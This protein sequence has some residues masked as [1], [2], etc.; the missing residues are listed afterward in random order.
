MFFGTERAEKTRTPKNRCS[1]FGRSRRTWSRL[2]ARS[3]L[4]HSCRG[5]HWRPALACRFGRCFCTSC[6]GL[7]WRPAPH[8]TLRVPRIRISLSKKTRTPKNRCSCFWQ[9]QKDLNPRH[10]VLETAAL[11]TEL[12]P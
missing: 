9:G 1:C 10:A 4:L 3:V 5:L 12:Y 2:S 8:D 7:H 6:R 11:P